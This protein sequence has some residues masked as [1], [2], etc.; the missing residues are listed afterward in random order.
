VVAAIDRIQD[1]TGRRALVLVSDGRDRYSKTSE[2]EALER[3]R[4][5][6]VMVFPIA[7]GG[8]RVTPLFA[9]LA[10]LTGGRSVQL[11]DAR[12]L[13][14]ALESIARDL[15]RQYLLGYAPTRGAGTDASTQPEWHGIEVRVSR[16]GLRVRA[17]DGY[18]GR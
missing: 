10:T 6:D 16:P 13:G 5:S 3:A 7:V 1:A 14:R 8:E 18:F 4:H 2:V 12:E 9:Q 15:R 11:K 17:R